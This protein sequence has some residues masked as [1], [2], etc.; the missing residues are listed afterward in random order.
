MR[1]PWLL[2]GKCWKSV[3]DTETRNCAD[4]AGWRSDGWV[5]LQYTLQYGTHVDAEGDIIIFDALVER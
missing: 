4:M 2:K 1:L 5:A 3:K